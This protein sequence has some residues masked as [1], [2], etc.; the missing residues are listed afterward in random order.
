MIKILD[1][2]MSGLYPEPDGS[3]SKL[4]DISDIMLFLHLTIVLLIILRMDLPW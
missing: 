4:P 2:Q 3:D 1:S